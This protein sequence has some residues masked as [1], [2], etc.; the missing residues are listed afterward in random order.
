ML[1]IDG[2]FGTG[3]GQILRTA[4]GL[5][6]LTGKA[7]KIEKIREKRTNPGLAHQH[8]A[9]VKAVSKLC[10]AKVS[11]AF[12]GSKELVFEPSR[13][14]TRHLKI[15]IGTAGSVTL[16]LQALAIALA[17]TD[18][19]VELE[20]QGGTDVRM[21]PPIDY[22][23]NIFCYFLKK[24]RINVSSTVL[25]HGFFPKGGG[26]VRVTVEPVEK[27]TKIDLIERG[28]PAQTE[29]HSFADSTLSKAR[30]A[31]R[32]T[33][34]FRKEF[35]D[36]IYKKFYVNA[37]CPGSSISAYANF[38]NSKLG[39]SALGER[40]KRAEIIGKECAQNLLFEINSGAVVDSHASDQ[41]LPYM[42]L[43]GGRIKT[44]NITEHAK[45][46]IFVIE[47][48]L[49]MKFSVSDG[50]IEVKKA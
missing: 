6:A 11:G 10:D 31:E 20:I 17:K 5:A 28:K 46:N 16:V 34:G 24:F 32:Q 22:F 1:V 36:V 48:F 47:K 7:C 21:A 26:L 45:T 49:P 30:V 3:G 40:G 41:L 25:K 27:L 23:Q 18:K 2:S 15:N 9:C 39:A 42:A 19:R 38:E 50:L 14:K 37:L 29:A 12:L 13:L 35:K 4:L 44:S 43:S 33:E 8:L